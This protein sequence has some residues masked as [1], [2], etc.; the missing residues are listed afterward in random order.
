[1]PIHR[2]FQFAAAV[3]VLV[4]APLS[5][6]TVSLFLA[7]PQSGDIVSPGTTINWT[8]QFAASPGDNAGLALLSVD[9]VQAASN[10]VKIDL[11]PASA[12]PAT[13]VN[14][15]RPAGISNPGE[16]N[17]LTGYVGAQRGAQGQKNLRQVGGAQNT[18]G[19]ARPAG[20]GIAESAIVVAGVGRG[21]NMPLASGSF[22]APTA[23]GTYTYQLEN[24]V[25]NV[26]T[27]V[28]APPQHSPVTSAAV[29]LVAPSITFIVGSPSC[30]ACDVNCDGVS[31][32]RDIQAFV[33]SLQPSAPPPCSPCAGNMNAS[34]GITAADVGP[35][36]ACLLGA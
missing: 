18:F 5:A 13:M 12:V 29:N 14:F 9:L 23:A 31:N 19:Q 28:N 33:R 2:I 8:I 22:T 20:S 11:P 32:G 27:A 21:G 26:L 15:S 3:L 10:P 30:D 24:A 17:P 16:T 36:V 34:G 35:F 1:M 7:S 6:Q 4:A 25:A